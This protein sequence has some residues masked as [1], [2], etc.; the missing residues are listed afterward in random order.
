MKNP[1]GQRKIAKQTSYVNILT[2][3]ST[4][5]NLDLFYSQSKKNLFSSPNRNLGWI[6]SKNSDDH[7]PSIFSGED[8]YC[9]KEDF[10]KNEGRDIGFNAN[11]IIKERTLSK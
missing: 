11:F 10:E 9:S 6:S 4:Q 2:P 3:M 5:R 7:Y 1:I 8:A